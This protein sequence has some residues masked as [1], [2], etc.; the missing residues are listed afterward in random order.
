MKVTWSE[1]I[2]K[3]G[4]MAAILN[5]LQEKGMSFVEDPPSEPSG[6]GGT[7]SGNGRLCDRYHDRKRC[8]CAFDPADP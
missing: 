2:E 5:N 6:G 7:L 3:L 4:E 8:N 1:V